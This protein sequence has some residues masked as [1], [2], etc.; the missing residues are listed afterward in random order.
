[1]TGEI[2]RFSVDT[3]GLIEDDNFSKY[4]AIDQK[5][6]VYVI[7]ASQ[8]DSF[9]KYEW[10]FPF[11]GSFPYKGFFKKDDALKTAQ[12]LKKKGYDV[13]VRGAGAYSTLGFFSDP[14]YS[15]M[16]EYSIFDLASVIIH[17]QTHATKFLKNQVQFNEEMASFV[18]DEGAL[19]FIRE[20]YGTDSEQYKNAISAQKDSETFI[21]FLKLLYGELS[22]LYSSTLLK[23]TILKK[24]A[25]IIAGYKE[26]FERDYDSLFTT[27]I[28]KKFSTRNV[29]NAYLNSFMTYTCD[30][31]IFY[32]L[33][34]K[35]DSSLPKTVSQLKTIDRKEKNPKLFMQDVLLKR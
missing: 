2:K 12:K 5:N 10:K 28:Y 34:K 15:Y 23:E 32:T 27:Q 16:K 35:N 3:I 7:S 19:L 31:E 33:Y 17:E 20:K 1:M 26:R 14:I 4:L 9:E 21:A 25:S 18:G 6:I 24:K 29:N 30:L 22:D 13:S 11:F 8:S